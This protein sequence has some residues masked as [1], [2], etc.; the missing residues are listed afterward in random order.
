M[1]LRL[2]RQ[3]SDTPNVTNVDDARMVRYA[4]GG[5][6]GY[7]KN[8]G[9]EC[10]H[11]VHGKIF[12]I[13]SGVLSL[14]GWES[15]I[16][17]TGWEMTVDT[18]T[19]KRYFSVYYE[20]NGSTG[21]AQ[22]KS[23]YDSAG[24]PPIDAGDDLTRTTNGIARMLLYNFTATNS[25]IS[26]VAKKVKVII[27]SGEVLDKLM[28]DLTDGTISVK[29]AENS[30]NINNL[31]LMQDDKGRLRIGEF[32][33]PQKKLIWSGQASVGTNTKIFTDTKSLLYRTFEIYTNH[34]NYF[35]VMFREGNL[36]RKCS[37]IME[38]RPDESSGNFGFRSTILSISLNR[39]NSNWDSMYASKESI[40][41]SDIVEIL[42]I[43]EV[44]E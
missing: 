36:S 33:I 22:I 20:V 30:K 28:Q 38:L 26:D 15:E 39:V 25:V 3:N 17:S 24:Y 21:T 1:A 11:E 43:Y 23:V 44:F 10:G 7:V 41:S 32:I 8:R 42:N 13:T 5:Y 18:V 12:R 40:S 37:F 19:S 9:T 4:Y 14:Q 34:N 29:S 35:K 2:I 6:D 27:Y 31:N 16:D